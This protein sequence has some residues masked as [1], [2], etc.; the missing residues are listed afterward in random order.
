LMGLLCLE[1]FFGAGAAIRPRVIGHIP[2]S[3]CLRLR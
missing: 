3:I 1:S 2:G